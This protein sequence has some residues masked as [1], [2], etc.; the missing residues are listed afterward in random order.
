VVT[1]LA[2]QGHNES[3]LSTTSNY[4]LVAP[5]QIVGSEIVITTEHGTDVAIVIGYSRHWIMGVK[6]ISVVEISNETIPVESDE[7]AR[8]HPAITSYN[9]SVGEDDESMSTVVR[10]IHSAEKILRGLVFLAKMRI[11]EA[12]KTPKE[13][14]CN[15]SVP[16]FPI[17]TAPIGST[18]KTAVQSVPT[19][20]ELS[21]PGP[22]GSVSEHMDTIKLIFKQPDA[23]VVAKQIVSANGTSFPSVNFLTWEHLTLNVKSGKGPDMRA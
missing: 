19:T 21:A 3:E 9:S 11:E 2:L 22:Q 17:K 1:T 14:S 8:G 20:K 4:F 15:F 23:L 12:S 10:I 18:I 5:I 7:K 6:R 16:I 13:I